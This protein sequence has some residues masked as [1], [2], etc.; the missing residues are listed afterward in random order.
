MS[1]SQKGKKNEELGGTGIMDTDPLNVLKVTRGEGELATMWVG[2]ATKMSGSSL[3][4][5]LWSEAAISDQS[6][7]LIFG[8]QGGFC[9]CG[10]PHSVCKLLQEHA[11]LSAMQLGLGMGSCDSA[12][13]WHWSKLTAIYHQVFPWTLLAFSRIQSF[14]MVASH[15]FYQ[16]T[17]WPGGVLGEQISYIVRPAWNW[18]MLLPLICHWT[19]VSHSPCLT[20]REAEKCGFPVC[21]K[22]AG[23]YLASFHHSSSAWCQ[24]LP[25]SLFQLFWN[26]HILWF[27]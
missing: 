17:C 20:A 6:K 23:K 11:Q 21:W 1:G 13:G 16:C 24:N 14:K 27:S 18:Q 10:M 12:K 4:A 2:V 3:H 25:C 26:A 15:R 7:S 22:W 19:N 5:T 8:E 9:P